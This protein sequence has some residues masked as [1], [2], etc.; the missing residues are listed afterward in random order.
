MPRTVCVVCF[1]MDGF[2]EQLKKIVGISNSNRFKLSL[3]CTPANL[4]LMNRHAQS[5]I[6]SLE[7]F[8]RNDAMSI[9]GT[10]EHSN[11][12]ALY[13]GCNPD[14]LCSLRAARIAT[15]NFFHRNKLS[16]KDVDI[17]NVV[18]RETFTLEL[19]G[20]YNQIRDTK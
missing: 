3:L 16:I 18:E 11:D 12:D 14:G 9:A 4:R 19:L 10:V 2:N 17:K 5:S 7:T 1:E 13:F 20:R 8:I 15:L 6:D